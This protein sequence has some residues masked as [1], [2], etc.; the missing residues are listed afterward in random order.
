MALLQCLT[1]DVDR[2]TL[3]VYDITVYY[4]PSMGSSYVP[5]DSFHPLMTV[6]NIAS[7]TPG[8]SRSDIY[9]GKVFTNYLWGDVSTM[10]VPFNLQPNGMYLYAVAFW[11]NLSSPSISSTIAGT[12]NLQVVISSPACSTRVMN[13]STVTFATTVKVASITPYTWKW[14]SSLVRRHAPHV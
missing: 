11:K 10:P 4:S 1:M 5:V 2:N 9:P 8:E 6:P 7:I 3:I 12:V 14:S 13:G